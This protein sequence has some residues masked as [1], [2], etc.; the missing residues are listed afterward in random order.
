MK[1]FTL[2]L[3]VLAYSAVMMAAT[4][5]VIITQVYGGG[6]NSGATYKSDFIELYNTTAADI[7]ISGWSLQYAAA[8]N[9]T[10]EITSAN[11]IVF[12]ASTTIKAK[13]HYSIKCADGGGGVEWSAGTFDWEPTATLA[14]GGTNGKVM[15]MK[16]STRITPSTLS[17][18][19][20]DPNFGDYV[21]FG[22]GCA[23]VYG[24]N[25][26]KNLSATQG[27]LRK[28]AAGIYQYTG[29]I[30]NDF[31]LATPNPRN[32]GAVVVNKVATPVIS[33]SGGT[34]SAPVTVSINC[35]TGGA[36]IYYTVDGATPNTTSEE[37]SVPFVV[38]ETTTV[39][40]I[41]VKADFTDS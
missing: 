27:A 10:A 4:P 13:N 25:M 26:S 21:P 6:G 3:C 2:L 18:I 29:D 41:A 28:S 37:Y 32:G 39:K 38:T 1:K 8:A 12:P 20:D 14:L 9:I 22:T 23:P 36:T 17:A 34:F 15:L 30:G 5:D 19:I 35:T 7:D 24:S 31:E 11:T 40:A 16:N 33:P